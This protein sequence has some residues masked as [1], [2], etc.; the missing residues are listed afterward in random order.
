MKAILLAPIPPPNGGI[1]TWAERVINSKT[2]NKWAYE[3]VDE[4][5]IGSRQLYGDKIGT[6]YIT[7]IRRCFKIWRDLWSKLEDHEIRVIHANIPAGTKSILRELG[8]LALCK[9]KG[10]KFIIHYHCTIPN[11]VKSKINR[12]MV[13]IITNLSDAAIV[14]NIQS[15]NYL[16][17]LSKTYIKVIPNFVEEAEILNMKKNIS[18]DI[19][20]AIYVGG[21]IPSKGCCDILELAKIFPEINFRLAGGYSKDFKTKIEAMQISNVTLLGEISR[22]EVKEELD[23]ADIFLFLSFFRGEGFSCA[24]TE[25]MAAGLPCIVTDWAANKDMIEDKGGI[26]VEPH[27]IN[28][29]KVALTRQQNFELRRLQSDWNVEKVKNNYTANEVINSYFCV[30]EYVMQ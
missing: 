14:L 23:K 18:Q 10:K 5:L 30:Y 6:N 21:V 26:V 1:G 12:F 28:Q 9:I 7:E 15:Y 16:S 20:R 25:A 17:S 22:K 2:D 13:K 11:Y 27:N 19:K 3:V 24:L 29:M 8:C 4:Q